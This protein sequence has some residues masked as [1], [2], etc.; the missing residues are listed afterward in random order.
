MA[1][2]SFQPPCLPPSSGLRAPGST[3]VV[4]VSPRRVREQVDA[5]PGRD[6]VRG[7]ADPGSPA[8]GEAPTAANVDT[9]RAIG[10]PSAGCALPR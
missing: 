2:A 9:K 6:R 8:P 5:V 7:G 3:I 4:R 10:A 1:T